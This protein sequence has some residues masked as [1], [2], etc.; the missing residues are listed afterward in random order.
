LRNSKRMIRLG[1]LAR[2]R[3]DVDYGAGIVIGPYRHKNR[4]VQNEPY[5]RD[6]YSCAGVS[7]RLPMVWLS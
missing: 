6:R 3:G 2:S 7:R 1:S 5:R 4:Y